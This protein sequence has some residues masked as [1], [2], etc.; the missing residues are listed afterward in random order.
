MA[1]PIGMPLIGFLLKIVFLITLFGSTHSVP[2]VSTGSHSL[3]S[4]HHNHNS[5][6]ATAALQSQSVPLLP[7]STSNT[8]V[9][10]TASTHSTPTPT[11]SPT[12][13]HD[14][15]SQTL[16]ANTP[17]PSKRITPN[18]LDE[19]TS[20]KRVSTTT[21]PNATRNNINTSKCDDLDDLDAA[22]FGKPYEEQVKIYYCKIYE[23]IAP[24]IWTW[25]LIA[26]HVVVFVVGLLGNTLVC[27]AVYRNCAMRTVTNYFIVNLAVADFLVI[28]FCL[29]PTLVW[30]VTSTWF[31]GDVMCKV[32]LYLQTVS[33]TVSVLTLTF[34]S[35]D[36]WYAIC[37]PLRFKSTT[38]RAQTAICVIWL[39]SLCLDIPELIVNE[40]RSFNH[41]LNIDT[42]YFTQCVA[43]WSSQ[44]ERNVQISRMLLLYFLPLM[45][46]S[47]FYVQII[48]VLWQSGTVTHNGI[49]GRHFNFSMVSNAS[50]K[51][52]LRSRK[53]AA[54]MLVSVVGM[55]AICY[56]PVHLLSLMRLM[57]RLHSS[58]FNNAIAMISHW[59]CYANSALNPLIYNFMSEKFRKEFKRTIHCT[60]STKDS[61]VELNA[62]WKTQLRKA[63]SS[64][65]GRSDTN[66]TTVTSTT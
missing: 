14:T 1:A 36:R 44:V 43:T 37:Y 18:H 39:V 19:E 2:T 47:I 49:A 51:G 5:N 62:I 40:T 28:L 31:F 27:V 50:T 52:Q 55:F 46:M 21:T 65:L 6:P 53:K 4:N 41:K 45:L 16:N 24:R 30:D 63:L 64:S 61:R 12:I 57:V 25:V 35:I 17:P 22:L 23:H 26:C 8:L 29:P 54:K 38:R 32:V 11:P 3:T 15:I 48:R 7:D 13:E 56:F 42:V 58:D 66:R 60:T 9:I 20:T 33:V 10:A 59:L 34:I